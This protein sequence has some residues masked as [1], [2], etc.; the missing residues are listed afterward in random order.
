M[1]DA[2]QR[3]TIFSSFL[4]S[5]G[6]KITISIDTKNNNGVWAE[7]ISNLWTTTDLEVSDWDHLYRVLTK[8]ISQEK[9]AGSGSW[10]DAGYINTDLS[11]NEFQAQ[12]ALWMTLKSPI[13]MNAPIASIDKTFL[14]FLQN[15][16]MIS[17][18]QDPL[19]KQAKLIQ[20]EEYQAGYTE[21]WGGELSNNRFIF[22][23]VN[24]KSAS[25]SISVKVE[26]TSSY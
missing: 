22:V 14:L 3:F 9:Y 26:V 20:R 25:T 7:D 18:I 11:F 24:G 13:K 10:N 12:A 23:F 4:Q 16:E 8:Q 15:E 21:V 5:T 1:I 17:V 6:K 19:K 2:R